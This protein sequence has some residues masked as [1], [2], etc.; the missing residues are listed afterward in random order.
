MRYASAYGHAELGDVL[1]D[2][3]F[4]GVV[5]IQDP[6]RAGVPVAVRKAQ[7]QRPIRHADA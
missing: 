6:V 7:Q 2:L 5:G 3:D 4:L 1:K